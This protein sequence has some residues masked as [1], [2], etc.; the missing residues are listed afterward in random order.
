MSF[1]SDAHALASR[2]YRVFPLEPGAK[3]PPLI[4]NGCHGATTD[5]DIIEAWWQKWPRANI[6]IAPDEGMV[7]IDL[8]RKRPDEDGLDSVQQL[9]NFTGDAPDG[10]IVVRTPTGGLHW[11]F[12][13]PLP[14]ANA[15]GV[16]PGVD[17]RAHGGYLVAPGSVVDGEAYT[18]VLPPRSQLP[19]ITD[20]LLPLRTIRKER[21]KVDEPVGEMN[22]DRQVERFV[23]WLA[24]EA[25]PC[26]DGSRNDTVAKVLAPKARDI[27]VDWEI[28]LGAIA[29]H[30]PEC[31]LDYDELQIAVESG[32]NSAQ[33]APGSGDARNM[34]ADFIDPNATPQ[35][36][37]SDRRGHLR[38][39]ELSNLNPKPWL[40]DRV[41]V[42]G[43]LTQWFGDYSAFKS[44]QL[45]DVALC[46]ATGQGWHG[47]DVPERQRVIWLA[48]EGLFGL[49]KRLMA[50]CAHN[51][52]DL[53]DLEEW[54][55]V[56]DEVPYLGD[57]STFSDYIDEVLS[58]IG[59]PVGLVVFDTQASATEGMNEN[60]AQ[61]MG[62]ALRAAAALRYQTEAHVA[63][64]HHKSKAGNSKGR[65]SNVIAAR[66]DAT[67]EITALEKTMDGGAY[68]KVEI[69]MDKPHRED[70]PWTHPMHL[71]AVRV[72]TEAGV[73]LSFSKVT[74]EKPRDNETIL[75]TARSEMIKQIL[76]ETGHTLSAKEMCDRL[77]ERIKEGAPEA[78]RRPLA[79]FLNR[80]TKDDKVKELHDWRFK[81]GA[82]WYWRAPDEDATLDL[83]GL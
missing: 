69:R 53:A 30:W 42:W 58:D 70:E 71:E 16:L 72:E 32:W 81:D 29:E 10:T 31:S 3:K 36:E 63:L 64:I 25:P 15:V 79:E 38:V 39:S 56:R 47:H 59:R 57:A 78:Q 67:F 4:P 62:M 18:G 14:W 49:R 7:V 55:F 40:V 80:A 43:G 60:D 28:A 83:S 9:L 65:G 66:S 21:A 82:A 68:N 46:L 13:A 73:S 26:E 76:R 19:E 50:W 75:A 27:G 77:W 8:D 22:S 5:P 1:K 34:F 11:Y 6:G 41:L 33:N 54:F 24:N 37:T 52:V 74:Y 35:I 12:L 48:G 61:D 51:K 20:P 17:I 23:E 45:L 2:G 44:F